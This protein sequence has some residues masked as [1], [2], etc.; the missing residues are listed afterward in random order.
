MICQ[1]FSMIIKHAIHILRSNGR[2]RD[3]YIGHYLSFAAGRRENGLHDLGDL[4][5]TLLLEAGKKLL[6]LLRLLSLCTLFSGLLVRLECLALLLRDL[7]Q[8]HHDDVLR[9][10]LRRH[11]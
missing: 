7:L 1:M 4:A 2:G 11:V 5:L 9:I 3:T 6:E 10:N 8:S